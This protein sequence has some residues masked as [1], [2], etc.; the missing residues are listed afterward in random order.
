[1]ISVNNFDEKINIGKT[2]IL[3]DTNAVNTIAKNKDYLKIAEQLKQKGYTFYIIRIS[4]YELNG[5]GAKVYDKDCIPSF[6]KGGPDC[7][8]EKVLIEG[9]NK[10]E[11]KNI[12][13]MAVLMKNHWIL[14]GNERMEDYQFKE[15]TDKILSLHPET[16]K[17]LPF[18]QHYDAMVAE[19]ALHYH[20][21]LVTD[22][23]QLRHV[24][25][26]Y[27]ASHA[28]STADFFNNTGAL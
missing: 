28:V 19:A 6:Y 5:F 23:K 8:T 26:T 14:D 10:L 27:A 11:I 20:M 4:E 25:N 9:I 18:S 13:E 2:S 24:V 21:T 12:P 15:C 17:V 16:R 1:M 22:D 7:D 3:L